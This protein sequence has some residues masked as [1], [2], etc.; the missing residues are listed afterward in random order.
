MLF[1]YNMTRF[2]KNTSEKKQ[3]H[4]SNLFQ[5]YKEFSS[6]WTEYVFN[7]NWNQLKY[8]CLFL[9]I[10]TPSPS[11]V[12]RGHRRSVDPVLDGEALN[13]HTLTCEATRQ[14]SHYISGKCVS[15]SEASKASIESQFFRFPPIK[16]SL[17]NSNNNKAMTTLCFPIPKIKG[18]YISSGDGNMA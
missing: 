2:H 3:V 11:Q 16:M 15:S 13:P 4:I 12:L 17:T 9:N 7:F 14:E 1:S 6:R 5:T 18:N 10:P 8:Q